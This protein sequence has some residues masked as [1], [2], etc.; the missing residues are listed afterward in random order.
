MVFNV[1]SSARELLNLGEDKEPTLAILQSICD[2]HFKEYCNREDLPPFTE[3][4]I[5]SMVLVQYNK[6]GAQ[7]LTAQNYS[8]VSETFID[9]YPQEIIKQLNRYRKLKTI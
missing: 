7:G 3:P 9:G 6:L 8:G 5:L 2:A 4:L 1:I